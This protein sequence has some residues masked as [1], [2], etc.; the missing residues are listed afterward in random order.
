[1]KKSKI[2]GSAHR[3]NVPQNKKHCVKIDNSKTGDSR[4]S[5]DIHWINFI[6]VMAVPCPN[7]QISLNINCHA[8]QNHV[9]ATS[10]GWYDLKHSLWTR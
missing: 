1:M 5:N 6:H 3:V 7:I 10:A 8:I 4:P 9:F 2:L